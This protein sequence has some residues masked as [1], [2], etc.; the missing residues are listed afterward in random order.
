M[1]G[2]DPV[3]QPPATGDWRRSIRCYAAD[4]IL[5]L[6]AHGS[7][8]V[9]LHSACYIIGNTQCRLMPLDAGMANP[10]RGR[11]TLWKRMEPTIHWFRGSGSKLQYHRRIRQ[12]I[13]SA[14][15]SRKMRRQFA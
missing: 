15:A 4:L 1:E 11:L 6:P 5:Q 7:G 2:S 13:R 3:T 12:F 14:T 9:A 10:S 8:S